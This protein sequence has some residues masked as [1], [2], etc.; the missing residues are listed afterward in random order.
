MI[1]F[2]D[3]ALSGEWEPPGTAIPHSEGLSLRTNGPPV[4]REGAESQNRLD[5]IF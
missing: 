4:L 3:P 5:W 1:S 2:L